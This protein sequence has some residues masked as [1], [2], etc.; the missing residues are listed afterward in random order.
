MEAI[1]GVQVR[2]KDTLSCEY[3]VEIE[4]SIISFDTIYLIFILHVTLFLMHVY[5]MKSYLPIFIALLEAT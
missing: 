1:I 5:R 2:R 3:D 4:I